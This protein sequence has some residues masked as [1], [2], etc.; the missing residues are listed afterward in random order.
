V[1]QNL[2]R[3]GPPA[4]GTDLVDE[5]KQPPTVRTRRPRPFWRRPWVIP[6]FAAAAA[7]L[8]YQLPPWIAFDPSKS[9]I[10][11]HFVA[12]YWLIV[13]HVLFG[14]VAL[15]TMCL[16]LWPWLRRKHPAVH[17][18]SG[19]IYVFGGALPSAGFVFAMTGVSYPIGKVGVTMAATLWAISAVMGFVRARQGRWREHRRWM[20]NSFAVMWGLVIWGFVIGMGLTKL[21]PWADQLD[22]NYVVEASRWVG[23]VTNLLVLHWW[24]DRTRR[25]PVEGPSR[26][27]V[28]A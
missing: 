5:H 13:G 25:R 27:R 8:I 11:L 10:P 23:W 14:S 21:S 24:L 6:L 3:V 28:T 2:E 15:V 26:A 16:Q 1:T 18:I 4:S 22:P 19:R 9:R 20:L 17:R 7:F 12:Q